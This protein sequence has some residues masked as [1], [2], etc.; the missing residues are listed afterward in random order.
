LGTLIWLQ[1]PN[2]LSGNCVPGQNEGRARQVSKAWCR[3]M[4]VPA[5]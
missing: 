5:P 1:Y 3:N 2:Y 4:I